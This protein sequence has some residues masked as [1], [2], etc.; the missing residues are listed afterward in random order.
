MGLYSE[1]P[2]RIVLDIPDYA[3]DIFGDFNKWCIINGLR[4]EQAFTR[5]VREQLNR[6]PLPVDREWITWKVLV[7]RMK[8]AG[9][10]LN[11]TTF[12]NYRNKGLFP[13]DVRSD[14]VSTLYDADSIVAFFQNQTSQNNNVAP[15]N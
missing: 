8:T 2:K 5:L 7:D 9:F 4:K 1:K 3:Q 10:S 6:E 13:D 11:R 14:G 15:N 12:W